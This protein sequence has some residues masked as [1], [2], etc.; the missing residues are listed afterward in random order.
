MLFV[1]TYRSVRL[2]RNQFFQKILTM[3]IKYAYANQ[4]INALFAR[5]LETY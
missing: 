3:H 1:N 5:T 4:E 2:K